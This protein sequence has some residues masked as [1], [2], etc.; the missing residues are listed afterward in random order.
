MDNWEL[1]RRARGRSA[2]ERKSK[3]RRLAYS[4]EELPLRD[5][6]SYAA[7]QSRQ[8]QPEERDDS[9]EDSDNEAEVPAQSIEEVSQENNDVSMEEDVKDTM[10]WEADSD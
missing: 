7:I 10:E 3:K 6:R 5:A 1:G 2:D 4:G 9:L 8:R